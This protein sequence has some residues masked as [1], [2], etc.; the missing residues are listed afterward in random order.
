MPQELHFDLSKTDGAIKRMN[1]VNNGPIKGRKDQKNSNFSLYQA[2][3]IPYARNHDAAFCESYGGEHCVDIYAVFPNFDADE[4]D[5]ASYDFV[6]TDKYLLDTLDAGTEPFYR[7]GTKIEHAIKKY[8]TLPPKDFEKWARI[9]E[10]IIRHYNEGWADGYRLGLRYWEIWNEPDIAKD[11]APYVEKKCW[12]G[13]SEQFY[14]LFTVTAKH[15]KKCF[16]S[17]SIGGPALCCRFGKW[18]DNFLKV[19]RENDVPLDFF[20]WHV[21]CTDPAEIERLSKLVREKLDAAGYRDTESILDEWNY[22]EDW[23]DRF[24]HSLEM[25]IGMRG[26]AFTAAAMCTG[27]HAPVDMLMY[28]DA[29]P[30]KFNGLFDFYTFRPLK[31]YYVFSM[32]ANLA[33]Y[34]REVPVCGGN[35][36]PFYAVGATD[37]AG[38]FGAMISCYVP[39]AQEGAPISQ[40]LTLR[41]DGINPDAKLRLYR[42]D[43]EKDMA[44]EDAAL[45]GGTL[46][47]TM[48]QDSVLYLE[49]V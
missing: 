40:T 30:C 25:L 42:L 26:A 8:N 41:L 32:F 19:C 4:N 24:V 9:C 35:A 28:Y 31:T 36:S 18:L 14:R 39:E 16:P 22:I 2:L 1:A 17:L 29:R 6:L 33:A 47:V 49:T 5:P 45:C 38:H 11:D 34:G 21:Y 10:H 15:L 20:S 43:A 23:E 12:G 44:P 7:L 37:G 13:S 27:Q 46:Q 3:H 48:A